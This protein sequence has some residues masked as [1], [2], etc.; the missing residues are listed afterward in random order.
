MAI[1]FDLAAADAALSLRKELK[2]LRIIAVIPF[3]GMQQRFNDSQRRL[4]EHIKAEADDVITLAPRYSVEV[5]A[6]RNNF[7]VDNSSATIA[8][9]D[10]SKG[11]TAYTVRR[12]TKQ[13]HHLINLY[14]NPQRELK[15]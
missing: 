12:T 9:F 15:L 7:L 11:G 10:G 3:E 1:G 6:V 4:F 8:F 13:L 14:I 5:Y 2:G